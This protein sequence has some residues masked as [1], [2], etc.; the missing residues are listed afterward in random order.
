MVKKLPSNRGMGKPG[1]D[2]FKELCRRVD[3]LTS[4]ATEAEQDDRCADLAT[5]VEGLSSLERNRI[6]SAWWKSP[7]HVH[8]ALGRTLASELDGSFG[9]AATLLREI[10]EDRKARMDSLPDPPTDGSQR[11][12]EEWT[13]IFRR[14]GWPEDKAKEAAAA[15]SRTA[16]ELTR[17]F[18]IANGASPEA[19]D[20]LA[21]EFR[22][23]RNWSAAADAVTLAALAQQERQRADGLR[24]ACPEIA[25]AAD[26]VA[27]E[28]AALLLDPSGAAMLRD[29]TLTKL[30]VA[31]DQAIFAGH[32]DARTVNFQGTPMRLTVN[33]PKDAFIWRWHDIA[34]SAG[35]VADAIA[36]GELPRADQLA[37]A[38]RSVAKIAKEARAHRAELDRTRGRPQKAALD[39]AELLKAHGLN[40]SQV[41]WVLHARKLWVD[42]HTAENI[43]KSVQRRRQRRGARP[44]ATK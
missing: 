6:R 38:A 19:A 17:D 37:E 10:H 13:A 8:E 35:E 31:I 36:N 23:N 33:R 16:E 21:A 27:G 30:F 29:E 20:V 26:V 11:T 3:L 42:P 2:P 12:A 43:R 34:F 7:F 22:R 25:K 4:S 1:G 18:Y 5:F 32:P 41:A 40:W 24:T 44:P 14:D 15:L 39:A 9:P 28:M